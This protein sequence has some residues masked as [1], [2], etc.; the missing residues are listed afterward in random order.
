[1]PDR[2]AR[3]GNGT[4]DVPFGVS[5]QEGLALLAATWAHDYSTAPALASMARTSAQSRLHDSCSSA[6]KWATEVVS[7]RPANAGSYRQLRSRS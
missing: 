6:G 4:T 1:M 2:K 5:W 3:R 7:R